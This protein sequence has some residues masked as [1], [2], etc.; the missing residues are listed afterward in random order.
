MFPGPVHNALPREVCSSAWTLFFGV[1]SLAIS[2]IGVL[3]LG[4]VHI[5][6]QGVLLFDQQPHHF[7]K[8]FKA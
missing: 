8:V 4:N 3:F 6:L 2:A 1:N 7:G 5:D